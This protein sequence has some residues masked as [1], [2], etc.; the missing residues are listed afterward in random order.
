MPNICDNTKCKPDAVCIGE[1]EPMCVCLNG[2]PTPDDCDKIGLV[3]LYI[4]IFYLA[5]SCLTEIGV[6][7]DFNDWSTCSATC[8]EGFRFRK[9]ECLSPNNPKEKI[10]NDHCLGIHTESQPCE[11]TTCPSK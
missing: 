3:Y 5:L 10:S 7:T 8:G 4:K 2:E 9:R 1:D 11:V 6:W